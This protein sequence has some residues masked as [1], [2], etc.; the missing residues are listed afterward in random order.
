MSSRCALELH[1]DAGTLTMECKL[2]LGIRQMHVNS[3]EKRTAWKAPNCARTCAAVTTFLSSISRSA[4]HASCSTRPRTGACS[5]PPSATLIVHCFSCSAMCASKLCFN[6]RDTCNSV[7]YLSWP[8]VICST[9]NSPQ[10]LASVAPHGRACRKLSH[11]YHRVT[12]ALLEAPISGCTSGA[13]RSVL[14]T[15]R[16]N[17][18]R[19]GCLAVCFRGCPPLTA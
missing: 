11:L 6:S 16:C 8:T 2:H 4:M 13:F 17:A 7:R 3:A 1:T 10:N 19:G 9:I 15:G 18:E 14:R 12:A 5:G